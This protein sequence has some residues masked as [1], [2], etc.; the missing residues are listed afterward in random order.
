MALTG[1]EL[2][3]R[4]WTLSLEER[5]WAKVEKSSDCWEWRANRTNRGYGLVH[6]NGRTVSAHR[7]SYEWAKGPIPKG[8]YVCHSCDNPSCVN[9]D[10]LWLGDQAANMADAATKGR[11][12]NTKL[13]A[14]IVA[15]IRRKYA[16]GGVT[17]RQLAVEYGVDQQVVWSVITRRTWRHV[18]A[19]RAA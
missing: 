11:V 17:Q 4:R 19:D 6:M 12:A 7:L 1:R 2:S 14:E 18:P 5:F 3:R 8:M 9:P 16:G 10:H 13:T 15:E